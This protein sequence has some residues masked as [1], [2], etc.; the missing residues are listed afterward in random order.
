MEEQKGRESNRPR[1]KNH[2][3][4]QFFIYCNITPSLASHHLTRGT[5]ENDVV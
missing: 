5:R 2:R 1:K 3:S 4:A